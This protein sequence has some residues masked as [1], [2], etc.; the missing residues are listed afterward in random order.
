M[1]FRSLPDRAVEPD[2]TPMH[3]DDLTGDGQSKAGGAGPIRPLARGARLALIA[4]KKPIVEVK[5]HSPPSI[6]HHHLDVAR[7]QLARYD[8]FA[9]AGE[10]LTALLNKIART[11][12]ILSASQG[13]GGT[14]AASLTARRGEGFWLRIGSAAP[15]M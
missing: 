1:E 3:L 15:V 11:C 13:T 6:F 14:E 7:I 10:Y 9:P 2:A 4:D 8:D 5:R 12:A